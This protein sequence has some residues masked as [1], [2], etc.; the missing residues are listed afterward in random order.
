[1]S[2]FWTL[3]LTESKRETYFAV[4]IMK[5]FGV[6]KSWTQL[7]KVSYEHLQSYSLLPLWMSENEDVILL[8]SV[9]G[10]KFVLYNR[11]DNRVDWSE[12]FYD[13]LVLRSY[14]YVQSLVL[15]Y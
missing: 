15:P 4:W 13:K 9:G 14:D 1:M 2:A 5:E 3:E 6:E 12:V 7:L 10:Y 11:R 8:E